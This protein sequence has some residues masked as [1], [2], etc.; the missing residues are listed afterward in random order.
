M[1]RMPMCGGQISCPGAKRPKVATRIW[2]MI[3]VGNGLRAIF[4][5][6]II[7]LKVHIRLLVLPGGRFRVPVVE[8]IGVF[9]RKGFLSLI[10]KDVSIWGL[11]APTCHGSS[12]F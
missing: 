3:L 9:L 1:E 7:T 12:G 2:T 8:C 11:R 4:R 10:G 6:E 5:R